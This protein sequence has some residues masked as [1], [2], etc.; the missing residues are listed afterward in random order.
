MDEVEKSLRRIRRKRL[1]LE[2]WEEE[3]RTRIFRLTFLITTALFMGISIL[4]G[5]PGA[6]IVA[7][8]IGLALA[9]VASICSQARGDVID[10]W[11][12]FTRRKPP[13]SELE[14]IVANH[15]ETT[16]NS[17]SHQAD[18]RYLQGESEAGEDDRISPQNW[19]QHEGAPSWGREELEEGVSR[20][21]DA[22]GALDDTA[23][24][25]PRPQKEAPESGN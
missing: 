12:W 23:G 1:G 22:A 13:G 5:L 2:V 11:Y 7:P 16:E 10:F 15:K 19:V 17:P 8:G 4:S 25:V 20:S 18:E 14:K 9:C 24:I 6:C 3:R 21:P